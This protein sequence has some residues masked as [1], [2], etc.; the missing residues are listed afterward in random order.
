MLNPIFPL[1]EY[2]PDGE[3]HVFD[4]RVY[5]YGSHD[6]AGGERFC[7]LDYT[8]W[9]APVTDLTKWT[10]H[11]VTYKKSQDTRAKG[12]EPEKFPDYYAPDCV[13]G[14]DGRYYLYYCAMGPNVRP[15]GPMSVAVG[16]TPAGPF[17][18][19]GDIKNADGTPLLTYLTND[20]AVINDGGRI[21]LYYGWAIG[22]DM[23][24][25]LL[26]PLYR[27]VQSKLFA[28]SV[29]EIKNTK[30]SIMGCAFCELEEDMLTVK[31]PPKL[32][33]DSISTAPKGSAAYAHPFYEAASIRKFGG[34]Y[35]LVYSSGRN[36]ELAYAT[37]SRPDGGFTVRGVFISNSDL[38]YKGNTIKKAPA[39]TIHGGIEEI[40]G[41][42]YVFYH[43]CTHNTD[44]SRQACAE[45]IRINDDGSIDQVGITTQG[46]NGAPL[47]A[48][49][50]YPA[51]VCCYLYGKKR[52][53][54]GV[55]QAKKYSRIVQE[56]GEV[57]VRGVK[58][59]TTLGY[60]FFTFNG[61]AKLTVTARG[62]APGRLEVS[63]REG[64][65]PL[66]RINI[67]PANEWTEFS[68][69]VPFPQGTFPLFLT[70][71]GSGEADISQIKFDK[72][73]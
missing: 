26:S 32:V 55:K 60:K 24:G 20:P 71:F 9:S 22:M 70:F 29:K 51:A 64:G 5:L 63:T 53:K 1:T 25:K 21:Y 65:E 44:F 42:Y 56:S 39:G 37:S 57:F 16:D 2:V 34:T 49:G 28:R 18:Y 35:Y 8:V 3:P 17:E 67:V 10:C 13:R 12:R 4:G 19:Y 38:G 7:M 66:A 45:E 46:L 33:L 41:K 43:R 62:R 68:A 27:F 50:E 30:P 47:K 36:N 59:G 31:T 69:Q 15:F 58:D 40:G 6:K 48:E 61:R 73:Q 14:N 54:L 72:E 23:R 11:G 52:A